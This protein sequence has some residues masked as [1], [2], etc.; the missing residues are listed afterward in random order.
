M[1][2]FNE[3]MRYSEALAKGKKQEQIMNEVMASLTEGQDWKTLDFAEI[4][5]QI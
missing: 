3:N 2:T 5:A 4:V 1:V